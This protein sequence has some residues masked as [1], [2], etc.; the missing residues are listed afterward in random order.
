MLKIREI[1]SKALSKEP[2]S[3]QTESSNVKENEEQIKTNSA[4]VESNLKVSKVINKTEEK[5]TIM[6]LENAN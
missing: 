2:T 5:Q 6:K 3:K 4:V 1:V